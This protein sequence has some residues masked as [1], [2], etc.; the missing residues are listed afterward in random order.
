MKNKVNTACRNLGSK[1]MAKDAAALHKAIKDFADEQEVLTEL[2]AAQRL[3]A[4][5]CQSRLWRLACHIEDLATGLR[6]SA[7]EVREALN[8]GDL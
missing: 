7:I 2:V 5:A 1:Q 8:G 6:A 3:S 4:V